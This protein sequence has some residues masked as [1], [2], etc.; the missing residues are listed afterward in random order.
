MH[1]MTTLTPQKAHGP[2]FDPQRQSALLQQ[3]LDRRALLQTPAAVS[4]AKSAA[5]HVP[6]GPPDNGIRA[7]SQ[8]MPNTPLKSSGQ[9]TR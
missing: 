6:I 4:S 3:S 1:R 8:T 5:P 2:R 7:A 9:T